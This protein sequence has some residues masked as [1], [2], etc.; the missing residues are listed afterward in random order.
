MAPNFGFI[1]SQLTFPRWNVKIISKCANTLINTFKQGLANIQV[2]DIFNIKHSMMYFSS[3]FQM[4]PPP[5]FAVWED[6][7]PDVHSLYCCSWYSLQVYQH[8]FHALTPPPP[9]PTHWKKIFNK[10]EQTKKIITIIING[11][12]TTVFKLCLIR[13][14]TPAW[15]DLI[16]NKYNFHGFRIFIS[17]ILFF[18]FL[19]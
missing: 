9:P 10:H 7:W 1:T 19:L 8:F 18:F 3:N 6:V 17:L 14:K 11:F 16:C 12:S 2:F 15:D 13:N 5:V 4:S